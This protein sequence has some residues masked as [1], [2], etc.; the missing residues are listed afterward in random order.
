MVNH[1][2]NFFNALMH[3]HVIG[4]AS[5]RYFI[6][7][8]SFITSILI[9]A[10]LGAYLL[11]LWGFILLLR[12]YF[13]IVNFGIPDSTTVLCVLNK[14]DHEKV[15]LY[16]TNAIYVV[17]I[18]SFI[19]LL[20]GLFHFVFGFSFLL[21]YELTWE[22][23]ILCLVAVL[24]LF[25]DLFFKIYRLEGKI[26][27]LTFYQSIIQILSFLS[28]LFFDG[29]ILLVSLLLS[30]LLGNVF[31]IFVF[32]IKGS[33]YF[34]G[35]LNKT[36]IERI[37]RKG[38]FIFM[39]NSLFYLILVSTRTG[40]SLHY[41]ISEFGYL[42]FAYT[43]S[44]AIILLV[45]AIAALIVPKLIDK[46]NTEDRSIIIRVINILRINYMYVSY[47]LMC[48][49]LILFVCLLCFLEE[50]NSAFDI[51]IYLSLTVVLQ[52]HSFPYTTFLM[53]K[54]KEKKIAVISLVSL[55]FN[56][57]LMYVLICVFDFKYQYIILGTWTSYYLFLC[58]S[59]WQTNR[60][61]E[62]FVSVLSVLN[63]SFP[64]GLLIPSLLLLLIAFFNLKAFVF[65]PLLLYL[66][67]NRKQ[68][69]IIYN[70]IKI[71]F[72]NPNIIDVKR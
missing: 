11:G 38:F 7:A 8:L 72:K 43:L 18:L 34:N 53:A 47:A 9:A 48:V 6:S 29:R 49:L 41:D 26:L 25:N 5:S 15:V 60:E 1:F 66:I 3:N 16:Q 44:N 33:I 42:T 45:D 39:Y 51:V 31:S 30:Y 61:L 14:S 36:F 69:L 56:L 46:Y 54:N 17:F 35:I 4:Y 37:V 59:I 2:R 19:I 27:E 23:Y 28:V 63:E 58:L 10:K 20:F 13:Q 40:V 52:T 50:Y 68:I 21:R 70:S 64:I 67:I 24:T 65:L 62:R 71:L 22:F 32:L 55:L 57:C 12:R